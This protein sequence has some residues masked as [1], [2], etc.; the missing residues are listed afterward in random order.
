MWNDK[1]LVWRFNRGSGAALGR[2]YERYKDDLLSLAATLLNDVNG[3]ED[4]VHDVFVTFTQKAGAFR[5]TGS[6]KGYLA[7]CVANQARNVHRRRR[8]Q[9]TVNINEAV[10]T[11]ADSAEPD[12]ALMSGEQ[13]K[14]L[15]ELLGQLPYEQQEVLI[16][17]L[18]YGV[19]FR[20][21]AQARGASINTIQSRYRYGLDKLRVLFDSE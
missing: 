16:L 13:S 19:K 18:Q 8:Q 17:H 3:A 7:T 15:Y 12:N 14:R 11:A 4:M 5:L 9:R 21:I 2:I 6:L 20:E 10:T 1:I